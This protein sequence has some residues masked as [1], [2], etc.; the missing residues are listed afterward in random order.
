M[1]YISKEER[2]KPLEHHVNG[3]LFKSCIDLS[4]GVT[5]V[6]ME[7]A[8]HSNEALSK[9]VAEFTAWWTVNIH[10]YLNGFSGMDC[11]RWTIIEEE[12]K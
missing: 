10:R 1:S 3:Y 2:K 7:Y 9:A 4:N 12:T 5:V 6:R 11:I 8:D